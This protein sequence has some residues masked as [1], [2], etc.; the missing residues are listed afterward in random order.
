MFC[1]LVESDKCHNPT[2]AKHPLTFAGKH[3]TFRSHI[4]D[5]DLTPVWKALSD[6]TRRTILDLL[7]ERPRTT[8][9]LSDAFEVS[10]YAVMKH[11]TVLEEAGL[12]AVRRK[13]RERWN[14]LNAVPLQRLYER[15]L[16]PYEAEW[17]ANLLALQR[18]IEEEQIMPGTKYGSA[19]MS[20]M[21]IEQDITILAPPERVFDA[22]THEVA[23]WYT[24][25]Y[26]NPKTKSVAIEPRVGGRFFED[27]GDGQGVLLATVATFN[28]PSELRLLGPMGMRGPVTGDIVF[29]L[30]ETDGGTL[31]QLSHQALGQLEEGQAEAYDVGWNDLLGT[32]LKAH[33]EG[34]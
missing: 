6:S 21:Q 3:V 30:E 29:R 25:P 1:L 34:K 13:G 22:L 7:K 15:W 11:L 19:S 33:V 14:H 18:Q 23:A 26:L 20:E 32:R 2:R 5:E 4:M 10:R 28:R 8:G 9:E 17:A 16:R 24:D 31:L 12:L 27:W